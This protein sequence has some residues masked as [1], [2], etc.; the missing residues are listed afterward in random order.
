[1]VLYIAVMN[2]TIL[3]QSSIGQPEVATLAESVAALVG[4]V[5]D[6]KAN[7]TPTET[8]AA[9]GAVVP[10]STDPAVCD[11]RACLV[12][13]ANSEPLCAESY[14]L[15]CTPVRH[16]SFFPCARMLANG[17]KFNF[18]PKERSSLEVFG[19]Y[20][21]KVRVCL[22]TCACMYV[23]LYLLCSACYQ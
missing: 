3:S 6:L 10:L 23:S 8:C 18:S 12:F 19:A 7:G 17:C 21:G 15:K 20:S 9:A 11:G 22:C 14:N 16:P 1:V 4:V 5:Q 13:L 2:E